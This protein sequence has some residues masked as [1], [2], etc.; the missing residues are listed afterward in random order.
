MDK[1]AIIT[2]A[3]E[4]IFYGIEKLQKA[5]PGKEFTIDGR[6]VGDIGE[7]LAASE[8]DIKLYEVQQADYDG[9]TSDGR[10]VQVKAT[11]KDSLTFKTVPD[12]YLGLKLFNDG[13]H[14]EVFNGPGKLIYEHYKN[15][16]GIG[17]SLL[18]FPIEELKKLSS[19][20]KESERIKKRVS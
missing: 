16:K 8:Y 15:R 7:V 3:L 5:F 20:V 12:Y 9:E 13:H 18:S 6:L 1:K 14:E 10:K 11:F 19:K 2:E 4:R 17:K